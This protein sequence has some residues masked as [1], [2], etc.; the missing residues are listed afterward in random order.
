MN[1]SSPLVSLI[2]VNYRMLHFI[3]HLLR[4]V[5]EAK[6]AFPHEYLLV[7]SG[8]NDGCIEM[9][10]EQFPWVKT[11][12]EPENVG[13]GK[14]NNIAIREAKGKYIMLCN[15]DLTILPGE[16]EK[17]VDWMEAHP[18][19][20]ISGPRVINPDGTDQDSCYHFPLPWTPI[21]RRTPLGRF[22]V[23]QRHLD[24]YLMRSMDRDREQEVDWVLGAAMLIRR[25]V[26]NAIG[27]FDER[28][29]LYFEDADLCRRTWE[30][31]YSV[32]YTPVARI[33]HYH[34]RQSQT[35]HVWQVLQN[36][37]TR[38]HIASAIKY[39]LKYL[40]KPHPRRVK[41]P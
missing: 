6:L 27:V 21:L 28:F 2:T 37:V 31:G 41:R 17:W 29:F 39:F 30:A 4:G 9:V 11:F 24:T 38:V 19:V 5:E 32:T 14:G 18:T 26:L 33:V 3:R 20:G 1:D 16:L 34:R 23:A 36:P 12:A 10:R 22:G 7:D 25:D 15:P 13:F 40:G 8:S 35:R